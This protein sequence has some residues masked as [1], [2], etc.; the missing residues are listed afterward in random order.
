MARP[1]METSAEDVAHRMFSGDCGKHKSTP[2]DSLL[3]CYA[4]VYGSEVQEKEGF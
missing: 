2:G 4:K 1:Q 3:A